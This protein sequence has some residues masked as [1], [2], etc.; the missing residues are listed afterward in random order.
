VWNTQ[1]PSHESSRERKTKEWMLQSYIEEGTKLPRKVEGGMDFRG[2]EEGKEKSGKIRYGTR[3]WRCT[4]GQE[5][6]LR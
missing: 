5:I 6:E 1:D 4:E 2:R 3:W